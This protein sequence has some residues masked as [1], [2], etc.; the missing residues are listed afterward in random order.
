L[1]NCYA[2]E[3]FCVPYIEVSKGIERVIAIS[4]EVRKERATEWRQLLG[5]AIQ[6]PLEFCQTRKIGLGA[7]AVV[8]PSY[9]R[10]VDLFETGLRIYVPL[11]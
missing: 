2:S 3:V 1:E 6:M 5:K 11:R 7:L 8:M 10:R 4:K 9:L